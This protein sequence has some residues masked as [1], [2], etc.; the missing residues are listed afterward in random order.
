MSKQSKSAGKAAGRGTSRKTF[1]TL[2][3]LLEQERREGLKLRA[4]APELE[5]IRECT[6]TKPGEWTDTNDLLLERAVEADSARAAD[7]GR[8]KA[9]KYEVRNTL[10]RKWAAAARPQHPRAGRLGRAILED[11]LESCRKYLDS[12]DLSADR[13]ALFRRFEADDEGAYRD[14]LGVIRKALVEKA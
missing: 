4:L 10:L 9:R 5:E 14:P 13:L 3:A 6:F 1:P 11:V 12:P 8:A 7:H 2:D